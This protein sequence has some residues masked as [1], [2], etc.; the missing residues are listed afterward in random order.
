MF[1]G[2][3]PFHSR[4]WQAVADPFILFHSGKIKIHPNTVHKLLFTASPSPP[5]S[6]C[7]KHSSHVLS[8]SITPDL[9]WLSPPSSPLPSREPR[10]EPAGPPR[11]G[12]INRPRFAVMMPL[13]MSVQLLR[14]WIGRINVG[15]STSASLFHCHSALS[16]VVD[17]A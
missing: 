3:Q 17:T 10:A 5:C 9:S 4:N 11:R 6:S 16:G 13:L 12:P 2:F 1:A 15:S 8:S 14:C 7:P